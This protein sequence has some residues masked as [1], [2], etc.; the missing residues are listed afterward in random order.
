MSEVVARFSH[1]LGRV[2]DRVCR[3]VFARLNEGD[4]VRCGMCD[5]QGRTFYHGRCP[6]CRSLPR[7]RLMAYAA[8]AFGREIE[9]K[10]L[11]HIGPN[12]D[13]AG[14]VERACRPGTYWRMD[15][16]SYP[17]INLVGDICKIPL[18]SDSV[19]AVLIWHVLEH[20]PDDRTAMRELYRVVR[21][22]GWV[23][24]SVPIYPR[25]RRATEEDP[26]V[27][28]SRYQELYGHPDHVRGCGLDYG[29]RFAEA[30]FRVEALQ[31]DQLD[32]HE[33]A[34]FGLSPGQVAWYC[35]KE[36]VQAR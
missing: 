5:W 7:G 33:R 6:R 9:G 19:D 22:G 34:R 8:G 20:I 23:L 25:G 13:E 32:E 4:A 31:V 1:R 24:M 3:E 36:A 18:E 11:L 27:P 35:A 28:R 2:Y 16:L 15:I 21:P 30:G 17:L 12:R 10:T 26:A 14:W 29:D